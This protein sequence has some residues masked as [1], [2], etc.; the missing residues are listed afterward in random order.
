[1]F[2]H[3]HTHTHPTN[4][5][6][7]SS[8]RTQLS[9]HNT[10][11]L[12]FVCCVCASFLLLFPSISFYHAQYISFVIVMFSMLWDRHGKCGMKWK[13]I[14]RALIR[15]SIKRERNCVCACIQYMTDAL[16]SAYCGIQ[17]DQ[18]NRRSIKSSVFVFAKMK[19]SKTNSKLI[20]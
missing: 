9:N 18:W 1:M 2:R 15:R 4:D 13:S 20:W 11:I 8:V 7:A 12:T 16:A 3:T 17:M 14:W 10:N 6:V 19:I 5:K